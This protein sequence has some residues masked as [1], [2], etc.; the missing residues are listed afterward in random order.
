MMLMPPFNLHHPKTVEEAC[1]L[2]ATFLANEESFDWV[3]GGTDL[4]PNYKWH[5]NVKT[6]VIS[7]ANIPGLD[8][9]SMHEIGAMARLGALTTSENVHPLIAS[10][11][12]KVASS[13]IRNN[14]TLGGNICLDTRCFWLNQSE[15]WRRSIDWC[16]KED[17]GTGS[18]CRVIPNQNT[19]CVATYQGD[20]APS[21]MVLEGTIHIIG[22][23]GPRSL[24]V[25]EFF[26]LDGITR[27]VLQEGEFVLKVTF[28]ENVA[29]RSGSYK[30]LRVR[31]S[32]DFPEAGVA[33]SWIPGDLS[34][35]RVASTALESIPRSHHEEVDALGNSFSKEHISQ[36]SEKIMKS[37]KPVNNTALPPRYRK[38]MVRVLAKRSL[39]E[40]LGD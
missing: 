23:N 19:L 39:R 11:A 7:L 38:S 17:C 26:Q 3:A 32:W 15:D 6:H 22:P 20:L 40:I 27:N 34:S 36:L 30:K 10:A 28:P 9:I 12:S 8:I 14:A 37:I 2:A 35:L 29:N 1:E 31:E 4:L 21:L 24:P 33:S 16:H 5:I 13:L 18:D 25:E